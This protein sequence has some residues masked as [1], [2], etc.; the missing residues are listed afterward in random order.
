MGEL[1]EIR[2]VDE[3]RRVYARVAH[4]ER[5]F[6][7]CLTADIARIEWPSVHF[8]VWDSRLKVVLYDTRK[9]AAKLGEPLVETRSFVAEAR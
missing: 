1:F 5:Y 3:E 9:L 6:D 8:V 7:A 4:A 2:Q